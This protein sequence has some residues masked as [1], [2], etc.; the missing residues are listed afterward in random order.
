MKK[1]E[2]KY[3]VLFLSPTY[4]FLSKEAVSATQQLA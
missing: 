4:A 1:L 3:G 2:G